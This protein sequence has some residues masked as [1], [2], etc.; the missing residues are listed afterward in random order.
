M[1]MT[2]GAWMLKDASDAA[3]VEALSEAM[4]S[5]ET[6]SVM[7]S[8]ET[9]SVMV[10]TETGV[11]EASPAAVDAVREKHNNKESKSFT[12]IPPGSEMKT[13]GPDI[14]FLYILA[15]VPVQY[16]KFVLVFLEKAM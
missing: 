3:C 6:S 12:K 16:A 15:C 13:G 4:V 9:S 2:L 10:S 14:S 1:R 5:A 8:A 7:V 11:P